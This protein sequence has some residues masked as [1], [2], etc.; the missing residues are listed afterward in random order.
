MVQNFS[1]KPGR[2]KSSWASHEL[3]SKLLKGVV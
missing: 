1:L 2:M 3:E